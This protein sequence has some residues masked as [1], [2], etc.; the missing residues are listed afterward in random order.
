MGAHVSGLESTLA[1]ISMSVD[2][3]EP[4][5]ALKLCKMGFF[6]FARSRF[7]FPGAQA[8]GLLNEFRGLKAKMRQT[9]LPQ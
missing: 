5:V 2:S 3:K 9:K 4:Y 6:A 7:R 1:V 8:E